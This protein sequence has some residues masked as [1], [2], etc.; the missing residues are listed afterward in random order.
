MKR[1]FIAV[2]SFSFA[3]AMAQTKFYVYKKNGSIVE[4]PISEVDSI[5]IDKKSPDLGKE[6]KVILGDYIAYKNR[7]V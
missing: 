7:C 2:M 1:V 5:N 6:I 4:F 3:F